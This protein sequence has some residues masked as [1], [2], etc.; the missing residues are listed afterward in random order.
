MKHQ[1]HSCSINRKQASSQP[2]DLIWVN[3]VCDTIE[4]SS[5]AS[6]STVTRIHPQ[7]ICPKGSNRLLAPACLAAV[8]HM[9]DEH[10]SRRRSRASRRSCRQSADSTSSRGSVSDS[11]RRHRSTR[12]SSHRSSD[13]DAPETEAEL[14]AIEENPSPRLLRAELLA[15]PREDEAP[16][17][18]TFDMTAAMALVQAR[19]I[20]PARTVTP[21][22]TS[23]T[24][25]GGDI[26]A[27]AAD[28][29]RQKKQQKAAE[30][31]AL[32]AGV[33]Q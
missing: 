10:G 30:A 33:E 23:R 1:G 5:T 18:S 14:Q 28:R 32:A 15:T 31:A 16:P 19:S 9:D 20:T 8:C 26:L 3:R 6:G 17:D 25:D 27:R 11:S 29:A 12:R 13:E 2:W 7:T 22:A 21:N 4:G 24:E